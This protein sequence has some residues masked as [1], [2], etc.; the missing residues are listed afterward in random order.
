MHRELAF[1]DALPDLII[2]L[3]GIPVG[4]SLQQV[5]SG[6]LQATSLQKR[7]EGGVYFVLIILLYALHSVAL[8]LLV[9]FGQRL[10]KQLEVSDARRR[11]FWQRYLIRRI[12]CSLPLTIWV[13]ATLATV[14]GIFEQSVQLEQPYFGWW[15]RFGQSVQLEQ[16]GVFGWWV[17]FEQSMQPLNAALLILASFIAVG[18]VYAI[19]FT[20]A[21]LSKILDEY[22][23][24]VP[25]YTTAITT[26]FVSSLAVLFTF[27]V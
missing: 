26:A 23:L 10:T 11:V 12:L 20:A 2:G 5:T 24:V 17:R 21:P 27:G 3:I 16:P 25:Y 7:C 22:P 19:V 1:K 4:I 15:A 6:V 8:Y 14:G 18:M 9:E 13:I